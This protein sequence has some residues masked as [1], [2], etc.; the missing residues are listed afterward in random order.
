MVQL[1]PARSKQEVVAEFRRCGILDAARKVFARQGFRAA[2]VDAI[3]EEAGIAKGTL[4]LYFKSKDEI[5]LAAL[6]EDVRSL[7][8]ESQRRVGL[9]KDTR[10]KLSAYIAV[11][12]EH[13]ER[14]ADFSRIFFSEFSSV[15]AS[16]A[17]GSKEFQALLR[18]SVEALREILQQGLA[19]REIRRVPVERTAYAIH[20]AMRTA[21]ER[22]LLG[23]VKASV[24]EELGF[25]ME[26]L[27]H[28]IA[29]R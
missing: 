23:S 3:A 1:G 13:T 7:Q 18:R 19:R 27:W 9:V 21:M 28:G 24:D 16:P 25:L 4:Y 22:R 10:G 11:R 2:A 15:S 20:D 17:S 6:M 12:L 26:F 8:A 5:Y 14:Y 29:R